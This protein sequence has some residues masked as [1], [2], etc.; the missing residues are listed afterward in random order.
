MKDKVTETIQ[1]KIDEKQAHHLMKQAQE[2]HQKLNDL[3]LRKK[4]LTDSL[5]SSISTAK[6][7]R[8][9]ALNTLSKGFIEETLV[10][11]R[12]IENEMTRFYSEEGELLFE[13]PVLER[14]RQKTLGFSLEDLSEKTA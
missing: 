3:E 12:E 8:D 14:D 11:F 7:E 10:C 13:R 9:S 1:K 4:E 6:H 2:A 5:K